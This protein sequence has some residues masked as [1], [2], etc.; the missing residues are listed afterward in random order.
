M[1]TVFPQLPG[2]AQ[3][4]DGPGHPPVDAL[5]RLDPLLVGLTDVPRFSADIG[6]PLNHPRR[7]FRNM[8]GLW[9]SRRFRNRL[10]SVGAGLV[11]LTQAPG[12]R[13]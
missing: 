4:R 10:T 12:L 7:T 5:E 2:P 13:G 11:V 6:A 3:R 8:L 9:G 1:T